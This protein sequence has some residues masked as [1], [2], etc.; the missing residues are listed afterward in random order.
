MGC[1]RREHGINAPFQWTNTISTS[2]EIETIIQHTNGVSFIIGT[3][4]FEVT[5]P[6]LYTINVFFDKD[7]KKIIKILQEGYGESAARIIDSDG[8]L[9]PDMRRNKSSNDIDIL[10]GGE[11]LAATK[12]VGSN[13]EVLD[14]G[15]ITIYSFQKG[16][17]KQVDK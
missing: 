4:T 16:R 6:D 7:G 15:R 2:N 1:E 14:N 10:V 3:G 5:I 13:W 8:D 12:G 17:W 9:F 11:W